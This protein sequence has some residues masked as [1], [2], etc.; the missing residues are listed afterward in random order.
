MLTSLGGPI[1][2]LRHPLFLKS[3]ADV[4]I[5]PGKQLLN[6]EARKLARLLSVVSFWDDDADERS[7]LDDAVAN[8]SQAETMMLSI[9]SLCKDISISVRFLRIFP[10][11]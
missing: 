1:A 11:C 7:E 6:P 9:Y 10:R 3:I 2:L 8:I 4:F 5:C